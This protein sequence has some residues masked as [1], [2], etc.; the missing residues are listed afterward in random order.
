MP[1]VVTNRGRM[2]SGSSSS[3]SE[4][5][6]LQKDIFGKNT[7]KNVIDT[8]FKE[9]I[10]PNISGSIIYNLEDFF[11]S[12]EELFFQIPKFGDINS[13]EYIV[14]QSSQYIGSDQNS[15]DISALLEE[16]NQLRKDLLEAQQKIIDLSSNNE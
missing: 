15:D 12:Y 10:P 2:S 5:I 8:E 11:K 6:S 4:S 1:R 14:N 13:H 3:N 16:I 7:Y 9:L